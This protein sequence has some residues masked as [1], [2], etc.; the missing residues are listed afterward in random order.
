MLTRATCDVPVPCARA[1][2]VI[3]ARD[4]AGTQSHL[5]HEH[6]CAPGPL[7]WHVFLSAGDLMQ[8]L[9]KSLQV[10]AL[11]GALMVG[12]VALALMVS[13]TPWFRDWL[14]RYIVR[15][16]KHDLDGELSI[17]GWAAT[18]SSA[19]SR[20]RGGRL[21]RAGGRHQGHRVAATASFSTSRRVLFSTRSSGSNRWCGS[22]ATAGLE[23]RA[24]RR[25]G[26]RRR[27]TAKARAGRS[28]LESIEIADGRLT[29]ADSTGADGYRLPHGIDN[30]D[31][32][33]SFAYEPRAA[34][35]SSSTASA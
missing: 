8:A 33:A 23:S 18:S 20:C 4:T 31:L 16:S 1:C 11:V 2:D 27:R 3:E 25:S 24:A 34:A 32:K 15:E 10:V 29:I 9:R 6:V 19:W 17:G 7:T 26:S 12:I 5:A 13:Q 35:R 28:P 14:R 30:L 22:S 21:R